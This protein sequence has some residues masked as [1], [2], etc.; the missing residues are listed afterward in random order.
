VPEGAQKFADFEAKVGLIKQTPGSW[1]D[2][3]WSGLGEKPGS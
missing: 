1:R 2:L 3:F